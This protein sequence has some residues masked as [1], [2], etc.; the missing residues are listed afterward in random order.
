MTEIVF[1]RHGQTD[2]N[3]EP[4]FQ[5][6]I[7]VPLNATGRAQAQRL[8]A[9]L[10]R[11]PAAQPLVCSDL[12]RA[13]ETAAPL[14]QAWGVAPLLEPDLREQGFG[15]AEGLDFA[16]L[17]EQ[18]PH[19]WAQW[20]EQR[21]DAAFPGG[22]S[23]LQFHAR[24][25]AAVRRLATVHPAERLVIVTH[26]GVLDMV[27][28]TALGLPLHGARECAIPNTGLN[29]VR[30]LEGTLEIVEWADDAHLQ[31]LA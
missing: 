24:V 12:Q 11:E 25:L 30:W 29:R 26:G 8:A 21:A 22:E 10:G 4:R 28:R 20:C 3:R 18:H 17:Q 16:P 31:D 1:I 23:T 27:W 13:R 5:G 19:L 15:I 2:M 9:R 14:A 7:D 6:Q